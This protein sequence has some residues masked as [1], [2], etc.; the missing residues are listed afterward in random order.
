MDTLLQWFGTDEYNARLERIRAFWGG[1]ERFLVTVNTSANQYRQSFDPATILEKAPLN[2]KAQANLPGVN[3]PMLFTDFGT[4]S[5][6]KYWGGTPRYD[7]TGANIFLDP[8]AETLS[9]ALAIT[10]LPIDHP[11][12][13]AARAIHL[14][15]A[16]CEKLNTQALWLRMPDFQ[17]PLNTGAMVMNQEEFLVEMYTNPDGVHQFLAQVTD[18]LVR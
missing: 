2:L 12:M 18:F 17:G 3:I 10:P 15:K 13:D 7:S 11:D 1:N 4:I 8:V 16:A 5:T 6:A 14:Y 9:E